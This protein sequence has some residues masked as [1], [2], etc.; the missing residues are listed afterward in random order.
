[1]Q[2]NAT[3]SDI[4]IVDDTQEN[5]VTLRRILAEQGYKVRPAINGQLALQMAQKS[6]PDLILRTSE[7]LRWMDMRC[8]GN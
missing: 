1:M 8:A 3:K 7:C 4:L 6:I 2:S 5:L